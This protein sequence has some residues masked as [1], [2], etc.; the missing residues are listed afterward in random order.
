MNKYLPS[1][2]F[3][4]ITLIIIGAVGIPLAAINYYF[5][6]KNN[7]GLV[8]NMASIMAGKDIDQNI[9]LNNLVQKDSDGDGLFDWEEALWGTNPNN[10]YTNE[11]ITDGEFIAQ[12]KKELVASEDGQTETQGEEN[13]NETEKFSREFLAT[14]TALKQTGNLNEGAISNIANVVGEK[15]GNSN[16]PNNY[17]V[18]DLNKTYD[19]TK[20][21]QANFYNTIGDIY[22]KYREKGLGTELENV[23]TATGQTDTTELLRIGQAYQD[24]S[25]EMANLSVPNNLVPNT[26]DILN[27]S[28]NTGLAI[29]NLAQMAD[30]PLV[31]LIGLTQYQK[32]SEQF[33]TASE[34]LRTYLINGNIII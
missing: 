13:L 5:S 10:K 1:K 24:F 31:G 2:K 33:I 11:G 21:S 28:Y 8:A 14:V 15:V 23:D 19:V 6:K 30:N 7:K 4:V 27:G 9:T 29:K 22:S 20:E 26:L 17:R 18:T 25:N 12:K 34:D 16:L 32:W 3:I